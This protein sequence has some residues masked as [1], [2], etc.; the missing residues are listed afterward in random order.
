MLPPLIP[1]ER[2][3]TISLGATALEGF[4]KKADGKT[5]DAH[6]DWTAKLEKLRATL[7]VPSAQ[8]AL[9]LQEE[10]EKEKEGADQLPSKA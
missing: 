5:A 7:M 4:Q 3:Q 9:S 1:A 8:T 10:Q 6:I 2:L